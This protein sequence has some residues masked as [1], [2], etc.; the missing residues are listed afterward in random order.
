MRTLRASANS[1]PVAFAIPLGAGLLVLPLT[2]IGSA[3]RLTVALIVVM[4]LKKLWSA[5]AAAGVRGSASDALSR[6][7]AAFS[8]R[9]QFL[10][11]PV[12][13]VVFVA[14]LF[15]L[16]VLLNDYYRDIL[17]LTGM[18]IVLAL[19]LNIVVGQAGLLNLG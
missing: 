10:S 3:V 4:L 6:T 1:Y 2:G 8:S 7:A 14:A 12:A 19:G 13:R 5:E 11:T 16:P 18:Y 17:T 15:L 9:V